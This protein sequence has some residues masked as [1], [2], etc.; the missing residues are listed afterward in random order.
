VPCARQINQPHHDGCCPADLPDG[1]HQCD[2]IAA[3]RHAN[4]EG[5][6]ELSKILLID[7]GQKQ[8]IGSFGIEGMAVR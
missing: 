6:L 1:P 4:A 2:G 8:W 7:A 3:L 5:T